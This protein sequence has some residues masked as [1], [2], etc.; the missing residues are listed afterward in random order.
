MMTTTAYR[1]TH[2]GGETCVTG[3]C[4]LVRTEDVSLLVDCRI[5]AGV[6]VLGGYSAHA[7]QQEPAAL[8]GKE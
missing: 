2:L 8:L 5:R 3:S 7:D 4:H 1:L 6:H